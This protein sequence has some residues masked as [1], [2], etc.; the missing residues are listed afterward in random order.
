MELLSK[1][2]RFSSQTFYSEKQK[3]NC[4]KQKCY[5]DNQYDLM[6]IQNKIH[7]C[8]LPIEI[9]NFVLPIANA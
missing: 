6:R 9:I 2:V 8:V 4:R 1:Q 7:L 3:D 5:T